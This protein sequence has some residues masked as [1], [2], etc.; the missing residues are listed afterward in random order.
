MFALLKK[1]FHF[2]KGFIKMEIIK[3][4][5]QA[6]LFNFSRQSCEAD[7]QKFSRFRFITFCMDEYSLNVDFFNTCQVE[8]RY[9]FLSIKIC[10]LQ[11]QWKIF[12][13]EFCAIG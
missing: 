9:C 5:C 6:V 10:S 3:G 8:S 7:I 2:G 1:P 12:K 13:S 11:I 4:L